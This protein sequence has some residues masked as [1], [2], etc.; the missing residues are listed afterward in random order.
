[1]PQVKVNGLSF[2]YDITGNDSDEPIL[3]IMGL[4]GQMTLWRRPFLD[5]LAA[6][7]YRVIRFDNRDVGLSE[8]L[9]AAGPPDMPAVLQAWAGRRPVTAAYTLSDMA[10]DAAGVLG[11]LGIERAHIVGASM[12]G[13]IAQLVAI[14]HPE[15]TLSLTSIMSTTGN[16][17]LPPARPEAMAVLNTPAPDPRTNLAGFLDSAVAS[18]RVI[19]SPGYPADEAET[20]AFAKSNAERCYYP[21]GF[22]RQYAAILASP[23]RREKLASIKVPTLVIHGADDPLVPIEGGRDTAA[24]IPGAELLVIPGMGHDVPPALYDTL[25]EAIDGVARRARVGA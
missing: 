24:S 13:M 6:R 22:A 4:G 12:G 2:E 18:S 7:G 1:M 17:D 3:L 5:K 10:A 16:R 25:A 8:K 11:A 15:R 23:D 9:D 20:R 14:E 21:V 19:G